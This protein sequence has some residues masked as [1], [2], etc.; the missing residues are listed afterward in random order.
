M[1]RNILAKE[2]LED[3]VEKF[4]DEN[5]D[6][7]FE[8]R[9]LKHLNDANFICEHG[10]PYKDPVTKK[11]RQF[12]IRARRRM[13]GTFHSGRSFVFRL[14]VECKN[15][16]NCSPLL[17]SCVPRSGDEAYH[18]ILANLNLTGP[19]LS[20][21]KAQRL[22]ASCA[23]ELSS[24]ASAYTRGNLVGKNCAQVAKSGTGNNDFLSADDSAAYE[25][26]S[27]ALQSAAGLVKQAAAERVDGAAPDQFNA[28]LPIVVVPDDCLWAVQYDEQGNRV[29][30]ARRVKHLSYYCARTFKFSSEERPFVISHFYIMTFTGLSEFTALINQE[31]A[32]DVYF[33]REQLGQLVEDAMTIREPPLEA[34]GI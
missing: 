10:G 26:W 22:V 33:P 8:M 27:Q 29:G 31:H 2:I 32:L 20:S 30:K 7:A 18:H 14:A 19:R 16:R 23:L 1:A 17:I 21:T 6:F 13:S 25:K 9:V 4:L 24:R 3:D 12:D 28:I 15:L 5:S 11:I 34:P